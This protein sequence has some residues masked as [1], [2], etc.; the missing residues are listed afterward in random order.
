MPDAPAPATDGA[1]APKSPLYKSRKFYLTVFTVMG[2]L[3]AL[4]RHEIDG[5][6]F[7]ELATIA[8]TALVGSIAVEDHGT[9]SASNP[10]S[11]ATGSGDVVVNPTPPTP[12][13]AS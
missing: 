7:A 8:V 1:A 13:G 3:L 2:L 5:K 10:T 12:G 6:T 11:V 9:K 4:V